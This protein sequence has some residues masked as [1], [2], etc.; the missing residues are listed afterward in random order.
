MGEGRVR[1]LKDAAL[2]F[3]PA[4]TILDVGKR[5]VIERR[6]PAART[7]LLPPS[8][9]ILPGF[10][11][12]HVH[13]AQYAIAGQYDGSLLEWLQR[14]AFPTE[15]RFA[16]TTYAT[17]VSRAFFRDLCRNGTTTAAIFSTIHES[18][19]DVVFREAETSG[20]RCIIG[21]VMM[22]Q[23]SPSY[24]EESTAAALE[25]SERLCRKWN[26]GS[27]G[28]LRYAF[29]PR[30]APTCSRKLLRGAGRLA[31]KYDAHLQT[32]LAETLE[33]V[34]LVRKLFP[35]SPTYTSVYSGAGLVRPKSIFAHAIHIGPKEAQ[36]LRSGGAGLAHCPSSNLLLGSGF[37]RVRELL[38]SGLPIGLGSDVAGGPEL[39]L[40]RVM[41]AAGFVAKAAEISGMSPRRWGGGPPPLRPSELFY[42][43]T[44]GGAR[45]LGL[46]AVTGSLDRGKR[47]DLVVLDLSR[48][49][50]LSRAVDQM[51]LDEMLGLAV[52]RGD[53]R[54][55]VS[56]WVDGRQVYPTPGT[57]RN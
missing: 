14:H 54:A 53:D 6:F 36:L 18:A 56:A 43:A 4:G 30:F 23:N 51:T 41:A 2:A 46:G 29:S 49:D 57:E 39:S 22:D 5:S 12:A 31:A 9:V 55:I 19:T 15:R 17:R 10:V 42:L 3:D 27:G 1:L 44:L 48:L 7:S 33:E 32:H 25:S 40:L 45:A 20:L 28:R 26:G 11:D 37:M 34:K 38:D 24:L 16:D 50:P 52:Y 13:V 35:G 8:Q 47:A 21:K